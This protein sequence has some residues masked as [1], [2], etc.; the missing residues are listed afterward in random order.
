MAPAEFTSLNGSKS[1]ESDSGLADFPG[2]TRTRE[3]AAPDNDSNERS[4]S[5][6]SDTSSDID[7]P[8]FD[9]IMESFRNLH[10]ATVAR[11]EIYELLRPHF[12][13]IS[14]DDPQ[15]SISVWFKGRSYPTSTDMNMDQCK[16]DIVTVLSYGRQALFWS[17]LKISTDSSILIIT[18]DLALLSKKR[19][20]SSPY[21]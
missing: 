6:L 20:W 21:T 3:V 1:M 17:R 2:F 12:T 9:S 16:S 10:E 7:D 13:R 5:P 8:S 15:S 19:G 11:N 14:L 4:C 18:E